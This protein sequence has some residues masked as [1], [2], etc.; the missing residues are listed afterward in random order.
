M[1][2]KLSWLGLAVLIAAAVLCLL[3]IPGPK[4]GGAYNTLSRT[5][6]CASEKYCIHERAHQLDQALGWISQGEEFGQA[7]QIYILVESVGG[8][9]AEALWLMNYPGIFR[10]ASRLFWNAKAEI[11]AEIYVRAGG[12]VEQIPDGLRKFYNPAP[13]GSGK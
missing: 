13:F 7:L 4:D 2:R 8:P 1:Y 11:Y 9:S 3:P 6:W 10:P 5:Y 12:K